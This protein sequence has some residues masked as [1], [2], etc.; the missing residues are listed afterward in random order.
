MEKKRTVVISGGCG[1]V[2]RATGS[3]LAENGYDV[4]A[5]YFSTPPAKAQSIIKGFASG[6]HEA[7]HCDIRNAK[8][9]TEVIENICKSRGII[10]ACVH[11]AV[12]P[13][14]RKNMLELTE[15]EFR[16]QLGAA[17]FGGFNFM[18]AVAKQMKSVNNG[19]IVGILSQYVEA[20]APH[21]R[22]AAYVTAK[23]ALRGIL[24]ELCLELAQH[25]IS[26]NA[27]APDFLD[28]KLNADLPQ[29]VRAFVKD[30]MSVGSI[31]ST[32]DAARAIMFLLSEAGKG[33]N[34]KIYS[35]A[36]KEIHPL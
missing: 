18:T 27:I 13:I 5:L 31:R 2:G 3:I 23:Y 35:F 26:V 34:G 24:K 29:Q 17:V 10:D 20:N 12:D 15:T 28:T 16:D 6:N 8:E 1:G 32:E 33:V 7:I 22:L 25:R 9:T 30:K 36:E 21:S 4:V 14:V 19:A 11:A